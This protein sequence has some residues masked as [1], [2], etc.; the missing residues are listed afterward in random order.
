[1]DL[2]LQLQQAAGVGLAR[3]RPPRGECLLL[4]LLPPFAAAAAAASAPPSSTLTSDLR[5][6]VDSGTR[7][8]KTLVR[9][10]VQHE[11]SGSGV[12][13]TLSSTLAMP[14]SPQTAL[15][16]SHLRSSFQEW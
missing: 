16:S 4:V 2:F 5:A 8:T 6:D 12:P 1:M 14:V 15:S 9:L 10:C 11:R 13:V 7:G 3:K